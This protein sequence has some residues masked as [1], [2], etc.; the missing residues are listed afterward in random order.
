MRNI[1]KLDSLLTDLGTRYSIANLR[2][3][4][5]GAVGLKLKNGI[6]LYLEYEETE[7]RLYAYMQVIPLPK[8]DALRLRLFTKMLELNFLD[9]AGE[10][11]SLSI[12]EDA[13]VCHTSFNVDKLSFD[14]FDR[15]LQ[16]LVIRRTDIVNQLKDETKKDVAK[17]VKVSHTASSL[18]AT[19]R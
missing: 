4:T 9:S 1:R 14:I 5:H 7:D 19:L 15:G 18:I 10:S 17:P 3:P 6:E 12:D 16:K 13:A 11:I 2:L 8:E